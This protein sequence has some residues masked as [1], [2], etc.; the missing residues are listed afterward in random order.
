MVMILQ[1]SESIADNCFALNPRDIIPTPG[2]YVQ[3]RTPGHWLID[4]GASNHYTASRHILSNFRVTPDVPIMTG[5][6]VIAAKGIG[7]VCLHTSVGIRTVYD[8]MWVPELTGCHN[9]LSIPQLI[10]KRC[11]I[12]MTIDGVTIHGP[13]GVLLMEGVFSGKNFLVKMASC[14][15]TMRVVQ[16]DERLAP[17]PNGLPGEMSTYP[18]SIAM[19]AGSEDTQPLEVWHM[20]LGHLNQA[21]I[22]QLTSRATGITIGPS[23][24]QTISMKCDSCL[25]GSQHKQ[26]SYTRS[27]RAIK[28]LEHIW[29]D[30][31]GPLLDKDVYG[32]RFFIVFVDEH[33]RYT[34]VYPLVEKADAFNAFRIF[35]ARAERV[36][37]HKIVNLHVDGGGEFINNSLRSHC[38][39]RGIAIYLTQAYSP[40]MNSIAE[41]MMRTIIEHASAMLWTALLPIG[42]WAAAVKTAVFL[43]NR[44]PASALPDHITPFECY[45]G[46]KPNLGFLRVWGCKAAAHIPDQLRTKTDWSS[47]SSTHCIFIGYSD[48]ENLYELWDVDNNTMIRKRDVVFWEHEFGHP[49]LGN[50]LQH[51]V[52]IYAGMA[53]KLVPAMGQP[54]PALQPTTNTMPLSPLPSRQTIPKLPAEPSNKERLEKH[55]ELTFIPYQPPHA[56]ALLQE[57]DILDAPSSIKIPFKLF[58][59]DHQPGIDLRLPTVPHTYRAAKTHPRGAQWKLA[60]EKEIQTLQKNNTWD[61][62]PLLTGRRA[63]PNKWVYSYIVGPKVAERLEK[64]WAEELAKNGQQLNDEM[65]EQLRQLAESGS[66]ILE[67]ARLVA[68]GDLQKS[69]IDYRQTFAP[70]VKFVSLRVLLTYAGLRRFSTK[71]F[72]IESAFLY[73]S[74]DLEVYMQQPQGFED[75]TNRVCK[76]NKAIYGLCQ[77]A[78]QFYLRLDEILRDIGYQRLSADWA[79]WA[80]EDGAFI[81]VHV[82]DMFAAGSQLQ[83]DT[84]YAQL[85]KYLTVK[86]L[87]EI[88][89][90]LGLEIRYVDGIFHVSQ[91]SYARKILE[92]FKFEE[93][94]TAPTPMVDA[95]NWDRVDSPLLNDG[96]KEKY[97]SAVGMLLYL[98]HGSRPDI[99]FA[100]IKLSQYSSC[101]RQFHWN[102]VKRIFK[103]V[104]GTI[105]QALCLGD[106]SSSDHSNDQSTTSKK[107]PTTDLCAYFDSAHADNANKKSTCGY[108]FL[109]FGGIISW[110]TRVQKTIALSSTEA[111]YM[112][113][114]E[115]VREA[116]WIKGLTD[117]ILRAEYSQYTIQWPIVLYG[118]NQGSL[119]LANN[120]QFH[121]RTKHIALRQRFISDMVEEG[122]IRVQYVP[123]SEMLADSFT[124]ALRRDRHTDHWN[125]FHL[126]SSSGTETINTLL[127]S[128]HGDS[129]PRKRKWSCSTCH[130]LFRSPDALHQHLLRKN[131]CC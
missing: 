95:E 129:I 33:S 99:S 34:S 24:P 26:I 109:L 19:L 105:Q 39:D 67:K 89:R 8:V 38:R 97:Q 114:T 44:S 48:T 92:E 83:L 73:G 119:A 15:S 35:E 120:P 60:M 76:L 69:G 14:A 49:A 70:V 25:R 65:R 43:T 23:R 9:L 16:L 64:E 96:A 90:Y 72:D 108:I 12:R 32:F 28:I 71:H 117:A 112:A 84:A 2:A 56:A 126:A 101:P 66:E 68:R 88:R 102:G 59:A 52:S 93:A 94:A 125:R 122:L 11:S 100:V 81:A 128:I 4:S 45:F 107:V 17:I 57:I 46:R 50:A 41:R 1:D 47:K 118:D 7:N 5:K 53:H 79:I 115:A 3:M 40:E 130:N 103:Y 54:S 86:D 27:D 106:L 113:G 30:L 131:Q 127:L 29:A 37:G 18:Q 62:V 82:D 22:Q 116:V 10:S 31:K 74:V 78:R 87:G 63:F 80:R 75:G 85:N 111:E 110:T 51:G 91:E 58:R 77:A 13:M 36:S 104:K 61:L 123:T 121:Q 124:K 98:M 6:G 55:K 20:R 21:A 42:F